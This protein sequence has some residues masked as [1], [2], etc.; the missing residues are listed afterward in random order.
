MLGLLLADFLTAAFHWYEDTYLPYT[1][2][3]GFWPSVARDNEMHH[4]VPFAITTYSWW[5]NVRSSFAALAVVAGVA[6]VL[7]PT[8]VRKYWV[9]CA[10][11]GVAAASMNLLHR[12]QH[13]R[14]CSRPG[15]ITAL[16]RAGVLCSRDQHAEHHRHPTCKY[17]VMLGFT[18]TVYDGLGVWPAMERVLGAVGMRPTRKLSAAEYAEIQDAWL[19]ANVRKPCPDHIPL[20]KVGEYRDR[21]AQFMARRAGR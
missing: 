13:E 17:S 12:F 3:P 18:N 1:S 10:T 20:H 8:W 9:L 14:D 19:A 4:A 6:L 21:L 5:D 11:T 2:E 7:F 15:V 16:Q